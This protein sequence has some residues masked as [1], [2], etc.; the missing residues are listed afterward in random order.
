MAKTF[1]GEIT[2]ASRIVDYLSSGLY[3]SPAACLKELVN[4]SY[5][6][7]ATR[8][9]V[10]VKPDANRI[11]V[12]DDGV[13]MS[14]D[15]FVRHFRRVSESHK[16]DEGEETD[17]GRKK[18]GKIGIGFIAANELC[19]VMEIVSTKESSTELLKVEINF[20][21]M[22]LDPADRKRQGDAYVKGDYHGVVQTAPKDQHYTQVLLK[23]VRPVAQGVLSGARQREHVAGGE[24][25]Y[26][27]NPLSVREL[28]ASATSWG[29][30]DDYSQTMEQVGL[31]V[32]VRYLPKW[33]PQKH[34]KHLSPLEQEVEALGFSVFC[35]G[36]DLRKP[37]VLGAGE[38]NL[39]AP[40]HIEGDHVSA[41]GYLYCKHGVLRPEWLNGAL[42]RIRHA[43]VGEYDRSFL[44]FKSAENIMFQRWTTCEMWADDRLEEALNIDRRTLRITH[45]AFV[46][47]QALFH[48]QL[49]EFLTDARRLLYTKPAAERRREE[50]RQE[51][52][53]LAE[54]V[55][56]SASTLPP[57]IRQELEDAVRQRAAPER[58][59]TP[60]DIRAVLRKYSVSDMYDVV[61]D[62]ARDTLAPSDYERFARALTRRLVD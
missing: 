46:E 31:N 30:F 16:R 42:I 18:V 53:R 47:L 23:E 4:N 49:S 9:D 58:I 7:D 24:S 17:G 1:R 54:V 61:M 28:I 15:E 35:D 26:G 25:V 10:F 38:R 13:G 51:V 62:V 48:E 52:A 41:R 19:D 8:V 3:N 40:L 29:D 37:V 56:R 22:R 44:S 14:R 50:A 33:Y 43:A 20:A 55:E 39:L 57:K 59:A 11:I 32:P 12:A 21:E 5:D 6:A 60:R 34:R 27:L 36:G 45:P 2:V